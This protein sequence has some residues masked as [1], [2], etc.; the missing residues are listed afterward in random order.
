[1]ETKKLKVYGFCGF[2][3]YSHSFGWDNG[4]SCHLGNRITRKL[5]LRQLPTILVEGVVVDTFNEYGGSRNVGGFIVAYSR[6][7]A[8]RMLN[9]YEDRFVVVEYERDED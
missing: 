3:N 1:M 4:I 8:R 7:D 9:D 2:G 6:R 5:E